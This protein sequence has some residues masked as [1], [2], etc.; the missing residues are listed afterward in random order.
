MP[1]QKKPTSSAK[2]EHNF[3]YLLYLHSCEHA[4]R[5]LCC[6]CLK[7]RATRLGLKAVLAARR[8]PWANMAAENEIMCAAPVSMWPMN[9]SGRAFDH[10]RVFPNINELRVTDS[11]GLG[12]SLRKV[13][14]KSVTAWHVHVAGSWYQHHALISANEIHDKNTVHPILT[15]TGKWKVLLQ[16]SNWIELIVTHVVARSSCLISDFRYVC[17]WLKKRK[18][19]GSCK[20]ASS[21]PIYLA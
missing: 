17:L 18:K 12:D 21:F 20:K 11:R 14:V 19:S 8:K 7:V 15:V 16:Y 2:L 9:I 10:F 1:S 5:V 4:G 3:R 6:V 13:R